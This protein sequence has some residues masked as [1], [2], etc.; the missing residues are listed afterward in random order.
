[1][2]EKNPAAILQAFYAAVNTKDV[3][4]AGRFLAEDVTFATLA[5]DLHG[6]AVVQAYLQSLIDADLTFAISV[7]QSSAN[8]V[9]YAYRILAHGTLLD[10]GE[11]GLAY[12]C[13]G[14]ITFDG[15]TSN[16]FLQE[17]ES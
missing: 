16:H 17:S 5:G 6:K 1:M 13:N 15:T 9:Q 12:L 7:T 14:L 10:S 3:S 2:N 8:R 11:D 4:L